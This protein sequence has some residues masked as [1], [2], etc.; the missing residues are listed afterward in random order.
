KVHDFSAPFAARFELQ[1]DRTGEVET[2]VERR[3]EIGARRAVVAFKYTVHQ[4]KAGKVQPRPRIFAAD[5]SCPEG[6]VLPRAIHFGI[7][8]F[9]SEF[10][11]RVK[12][13]SRRTYVFVDPENTMVVIHHFAQIGEALRRRLAR[14]NRVIKLLVIVFTRRAAY[15]HW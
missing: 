14:R 12:M 8:A 3:P 7:A 11:P 10:R 13:V 4:Y 2:R 9:T 1:R 5:R 6:P 15:G